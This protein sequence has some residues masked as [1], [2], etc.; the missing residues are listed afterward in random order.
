MFAVEENVSQFSMFGWLKI[1]GNIFSRKTSSL[2]VS[3]WTRGNKFYKWCST[4]IVSFPPSNIPNPLL[5]PLP[6]LYSV[7]LDCTQMFL[8][9][10]FCLCTEHIKLSMETT[11]FCKKIFPREHFPSKPNTPL[12]FWIENKMREGEVLLEW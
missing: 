7:C 8:N 2:K 3:K 9:N 10:I 5:P 6:N 12:I 1:L 4:L 11:Y